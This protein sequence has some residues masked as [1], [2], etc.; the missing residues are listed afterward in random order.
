MTARRL[1]RGRERAGIY[2]MRLHL[3]RHPLGRAKHCYCLIGLV[4]L[5]RCGSSPGLPTQGGAVAPKTAHITVL[6]QQGHSIPGALVS[7]C[8]PTGGR[9]EERTQTV[10][11]TGQA[12][13]VGLPPGE[14]PVQV[15]LS[16]FRMSTPHPQLRVSES[17]TAPLV[18]T[19]EVFYGPH[20]Y[21]LGPTPVPTRS[22]CDVAA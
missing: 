14:Y 13:F 3:T 15:Y 21:G 17:G 18:V 5:V 2:G 1:G 20:N 11:S 9:A 22:H 12:D 10:G 16:G 6:D 8:V 7:I 19:L 4:L